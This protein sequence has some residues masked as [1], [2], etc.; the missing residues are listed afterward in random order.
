MSES[1]KN[2]IFTCDEYL[3]DPDDVLFRG[4]DINVAPEQVFSWL[5]QLR[6]A[7]YS[8]DWIDNKGKRSPRTLDPKLQNL[9]IGQKF[10][11]FELAHFKKNEQIT[12]ITKTR[13]VE[14]FFGKIAMTY[15]V[16]EITPSTSRLLVKMLVKRSTRKLFAALLPWGDWVMMR[17]QLLTLKELAEDSKKYYKI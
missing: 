6:I 7:P 11:I 15:L 17:K 12:L 14:N 5:C 10:I 13:E 16:K 9:S 8:Y 1:E 4:I 3:I 2:Q